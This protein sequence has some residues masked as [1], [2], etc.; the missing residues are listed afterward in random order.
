M[1][2]GVTGYDCAG[3]GTVVSYL[4]GK[5]F[6]AYSLSDEVRYECDARELPREKEVLVRVANELRRDFGNE[7]LA[8]RVIRK[9]VAG[10]N[11]ALDSFRNPAEVQALKEYAQTNQQ[12]FLLAAVD[13]PLEL[14]FERG[15]AAGKPGHPKTLEEFRARHER[16]KAEGIAHGQNIGACVALADVH[17]EN[18][19]SESGLYRKLDMILAHPERFVGT[20]TM[21]V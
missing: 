1:I 12:Q 11:Y 8:Q 6:Q 21:L 17:I 4:A 7:V 13:A 15:I 20:G 2:I 5:G 14:R 10:M 18:K 3:K 16:D 9:L 19:R